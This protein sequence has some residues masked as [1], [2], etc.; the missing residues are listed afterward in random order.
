MWPYWV[1]FLIPAGAALLSKQSGKMT[2][3]GW[4]PGSTDMGWVFTWI[5]ITVLIGF[6]YRVGGD[7]FAYMRALDATRGL[8]VADALTRSDPGYALLNWLS[9]EMGWGIYGVNLIG[10]AIFAFGLMEL[11]S[12]QP[13]RWVALTAAI[14]YLVIVV[15]MG[16]SRQAIA[17]GFT[18]LGLVALNNSSILRFAIWVALGATFHKTA[19][20]LMP[21]GALSATRNRYWT[22]V[23]MAVFFL[24]LYEV[25][26]ETEAD[27]LYRNYIVAQFQSQ[28]AL[29][30]LL[31][32]A[33]P[34]VAFLMWRRKFLFARTEARLWTWVAIISLALLVLYAVSPSSTVVDRM[35]LYMLPLQ[36]VVFARLP[37]VF[38]KQDW[39][40]QIQK[41]AGIST[42][43][44]EK[45][46]SGHAD[47][48]TVA[49]VL[50]YAAVLFV[51]L[52]FADNAEDWLPYRFYPLEQVF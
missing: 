6:R 22:T 49:V 5:L 38:G 41:V 4:R 34:A 46:S 51:W 35:A 21:I 15:A 2:S 42:D 43:F 20:L 48:F 9:Q 18:M 36:L 50:Y 1:L 29:V 45:S 26:F 16:Y 13:R 19:V 52:N 10:G 32:N 28:G 7:W 14:P 40:G 44:E 24:T 3:A 8:D 33:V 39:L 37:V 47:I 17:L 23:W 25:L 12:N 30:R 31:M 27:A 11:C